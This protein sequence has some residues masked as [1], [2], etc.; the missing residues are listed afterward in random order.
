MP[1]S[2]KRYPLNQSPLFKLKSRSK[3]AELL[4]LQNKQLRWLSK[5]S[6]ELYKEKDRPKKDGSGLRHIEDPRKLLKQVQSRLASLLSR[7]EPPDYLFC[8]VKGRDYI[9][10]AGQHRGNRVVRCLDVRKYFP[11]TSSRRVFWFFHTVLK[12]ER[13][14][15]GVLTEIS[16]FKGHLPTG[17]PLSPILSYFAHID[18]WNAVANICTAN[19]CTL[20]VYID[21]VTVSGSK[22]TAKIM[23][24][25]KRAIHRSGLRYHKEKFFVDGPS[26]ITGVI[27]KG[28][29]LMPPHRQHKKIRVSEK[30]LKRESNFTSAQKILGRLNGLKGQLNQIRAE[31]RKSPFVIR[32]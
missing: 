13:D 31:A 26:E 7:I 19:D 12:C 4:K 21:D 9:K 2:L 10:N 20:T 23:W 28:D 22:L 29:V 25:V 3:L 16:C 8:P 32:G 27:V 30:I 24:D 18:V 1:S 17:S 6:N 15:A 14:L 5:F 11:S